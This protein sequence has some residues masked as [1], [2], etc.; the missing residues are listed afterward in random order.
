MLNM[1]SIHAKTQHG[2]TLIE[3]LVAAAIV[4]MSIGTIMQ[5]FGSGLDQNKRIGQLAHLLT[6][7][8]TIMA[9]MEYINPA[10]QAEGEGVAETLHYQWHAKI[11]EPYQRIYQ[12]ENSFPREIALF[13]INVQIE[14]PRGGHYQFTLK[15]L[16]W[17]EQS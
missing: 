12:E 16:G 14:K 4:I 9:R 5:L 10:Q 6:A 11:A 8:R 3:V 7:Q 13:T 2:F 15:R 1:T 17:R